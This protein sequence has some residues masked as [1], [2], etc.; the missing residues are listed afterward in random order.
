MVPN[1][2]FIVES[3]TNHK[4][5]MQRYRVDFSVAYHSNIRPLAAII[6]DVVAS[7]PQV[8]SG[9][10]VPLEE[11][12]DCEIDSFGDSASTYSSNSGWR[13]STTAE[14]GSAAICY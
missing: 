14:T 13:G 12:P 11:Q 10:D 1:E 2:K 5:K 6:K 9:G 8:I 3:F 7:H 4:N